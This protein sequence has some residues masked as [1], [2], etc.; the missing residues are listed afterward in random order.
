MGTCSAYNYSQGYKATVFLHYMYMHVLRGKPGKRG[1]IHV[2]Y[3]VYIALA[4][5]CLCSETNMAKTY[6]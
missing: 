2:G 3:I 5:D 4:S 6:R 1:Y